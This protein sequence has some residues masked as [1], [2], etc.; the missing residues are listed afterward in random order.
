MTSTWIYP[1]QTLKQKTQQ[2][3]S[4]TP[5]HGFCEVMEVCDF[6]LLSLWCYET[7]TMD[8]SPICT[9][10]YFIYHVS[11]MENWGILKK[12]KTHPILSSWSLWDRSELRLLGNLYMVSHVKAAKICPFPGAGL[13]DLHD[14]A[15]PALV[16]SREAGFPVVSTIQG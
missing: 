6:K 4:W 12:K 11:R 8:V 7:K 5:D 1:G 14:R 2:S 15:G 9:D 13:F 3:C 16:H 10:I